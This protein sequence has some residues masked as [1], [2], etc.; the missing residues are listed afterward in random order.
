VKKLLIVLIF[1]ALG[2]A[3]LASYTRYSHNR[4]SDDEFTRAQITFGQMR[5]IVGVQSMLRPQHVRPVFSKI[6]GQVVDFKR[7]AGELVEEDQILVQLDQK[8]ALLKR[9]EAASV[10]EAAKSAVKAAESTLEQAEAKREAA[11]EVVDTLKKLTTGPI[12]K[13]KAQGELK[14]AEGAVKGANGAIAL[15]KSKEKVAETQL[16]EANYGLEVTTIRAPAF[17]MEDAKPKEPASANVQSDESKARPKR[18]Y[19]VLECKVERGQNVD[20]KEP[21]FVLVTDLEEMQADALVPESQIG[22][23]APGQQ[24]QFWVDSIGEENK[25]DAIVSEIRLKPVTQ[26]GAVYYPV[27][28]NIKNRKN[29]KTGEWQLRPG[30]TAQVEI[31]DRTHPGVW[32]L[33]VNARSFTLDDHHQTAEAKAHAAQAE[34]RLDMSVWTKIWI[35]RD[36]KPW[37]VFVRLNG[38]NAAGDTGIKDAEYYEILEWDAETMPP[39]LNPKDK[40]TYPE[41]IIGAPPKK[42]M[43]ELP[44]IKF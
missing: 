32:K 7:K 17:D 37:P 11:Q 8:Q 41:V 19:L 24:A 42:S 13:A 3:G 44:N 16:A 29:A 31:V 15:A 21:L 20:V 34:R 28:L 10:L 26:P 23:V 39:G 14:A 18:K 2:L 40:A 27:L 1:V 25:I 43:F 38:T 30:M 6:P 35:L 33:P 4:P 22:R 5:D 9:D 36:N 12:E